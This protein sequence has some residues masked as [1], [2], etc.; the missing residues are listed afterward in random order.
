MPTA[1]ALNILEEFLLGTSDQ[2]PDTDFDTLPDG[3]EVAQGRNP[4]LADY[5]IS[6]GAESSCALTD[7]GIVCWGKDNGSLNV[8]NLYNPT[9]V[10]VGNTFACAL[11]NSEEICWGNNQESLIGKPSLIESACSIEASDIVCQTMP[12]L[13][14]L[15]SLRTQRK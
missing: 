11:E 5:Q 6:T 2:N 12:C 13:D 3:W 9:A 10:A 14:P 4:L 1:M 8:P 7:N 15:L